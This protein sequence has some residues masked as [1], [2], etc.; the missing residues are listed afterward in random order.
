M[1]V[2]PLLVLVTCYYK[3]TND[4]YLQVDHPF[5]WH[6]TLLLHHPARSSLWQ[7]NPGHDR[8]RP[9]LGGRFDSHSSC[10]P[11]KCNKMHAGRKAPSSEGVL[12]IAA[13]LH[14]DS[15]ASPVTHLADPHC[16][17]NYTTRFTVTHLFDMN[18]T[19]NKKSAIK[20]KPG[21]HKRTKRQ[22]DKTYIEYPSHPFD[23]SWTFCCCG[24]VGLL[25]RGCIVL[26]TFLCRR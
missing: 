25:I 1:L 19:H 10:Q 7:T 24:S 20:E 5:C 21:Q 9:S 17:R 16:I 3:N 26:G 12:T 15:M 18:I 23:P 22:L 2:L 11:P 6:L 8:C 4:F 14:P 13:Q